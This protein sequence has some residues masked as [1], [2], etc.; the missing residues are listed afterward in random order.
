MQLVDSLSDTGY[1]NS[2]VVKP[3]RPGVAQIESWD[4]NDWGRLAGDSF[5]MQIL[6]DLFCQRFFD[7]RMS[8]N[9][10]DGSCFWVY[11]Q[12]MGSALPLKVTAGDPK[13]LLQ[14]PSLHP[15]AIVSLITSSGKPR[16]TSSR[17]S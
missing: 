9:R 7:F 5:C 6:D 14:I 16:L 11:P 1:T 4:N 2:P 8:R 12:G 17:R 13:L 15:T 3:R 10:F